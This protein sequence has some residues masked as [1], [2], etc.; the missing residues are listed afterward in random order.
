MGD[1][2]AIMRPAWAPADLAMDRVQWAQTTMNFYTRSL[3][4]DKQGVHQ[5]REGMPEEKI[6]EI[7]RGEELHYISECKKLLL[8]TPSSLSESSI[9]FCK[10]FME[11]RKKWWQEDW[12]MW[13]AV[14]GA[15]LVG[16]AIMGDDDVRS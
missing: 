9:P 14:G 8:G 11:K 12:V 6:K 5:P 3:A 1:L 10:T 15:V 2:L 4:L 16:I 7:V 13:A